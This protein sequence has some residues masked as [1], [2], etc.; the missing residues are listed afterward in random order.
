[1]AKLW[2]QKIQNRLR[3]AGVTPTRQHVQEKS[4]YF[5]QLFFISGR[6]SSEFGMI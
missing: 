4:I 5:L 6:L 3:M 1:M 2:R